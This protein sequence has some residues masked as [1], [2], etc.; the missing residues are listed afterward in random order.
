MKS[1]DSVRETHDKY[2]NIIKW[3]NFGTDQRFLS[4]WAV[5]FLALK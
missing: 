5:G 2:K 4:I 3:N 1:C